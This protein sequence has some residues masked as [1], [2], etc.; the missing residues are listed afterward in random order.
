MKARNV[1]AMSLLSNA[2]WTIA[3]ED[4]VAAP[5]PGSIDP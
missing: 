5:V 1:T 4:L 3:E 2:V